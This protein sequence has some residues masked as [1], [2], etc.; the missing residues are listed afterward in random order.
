MIEAARRQTA[1]AVN[2]GLTVLYWRVGKG[3]HLEVKIH[4]A[5]GVEEM[6]RRWSVGDLGGKTF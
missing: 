6:L 2:I 1:V 3:I 5:T 4:R